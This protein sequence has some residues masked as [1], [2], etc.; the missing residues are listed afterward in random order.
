MIEH[1][2]QEVG[3]SNQSAEIRDGEVAELNAALNAL[4]PIERAMDLMCC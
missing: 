3:L 1:Q 4:F 2:L